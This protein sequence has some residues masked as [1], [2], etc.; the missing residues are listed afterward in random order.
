MNNP[1]LQVGSQVG[2]DGARRSLARQQYGR[3]QVFPPTW[4]V[5]E[6][7]PVMQ[8]VLPAAKVT[9]AFLALDNPDVANTAYQFVWVLTFGAGGTQINLEIDA[10]NAQQISL[11]VSGISVDLKVKRTFPTALFDPPPLPVVA[12]AFIGEY[13]V[14]SGEARLTQGFDIVGLGTETFIPPKGASGWRVAG[15]LGGASS[16]FNAAFTYSVRSA[17]AFDA[18]TGL[19]LLDVRQAGIFLPFPNATRSIVL[20]NGNANATAGSII[21]QLDL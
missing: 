1:F 8:S 15:G 4:Q 16:P 3:S 19:Q 18:Y 17:I 2:R 14:Y 5:D 12:T 10:T 11:P 20:S 7:R 6:S 13:A 9:S 21:Y